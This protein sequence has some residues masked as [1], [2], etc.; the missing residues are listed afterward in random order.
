MSGRIGVAGLGLMGSAIAGHLVAAHP[1]RVV[2][3]N[4]DPARSEPLGRLGTDI[5]A[6]PS[7]LA[8]R[9]SVVHLSLLDTAAVEEVAAAI[10]DVPKDDGLIL[11]HST[12]SAVSTREIAARAAQNGWTWVDAPVSGGSTGARAGQ[13]AVFL[14]GP[15]AQMDRARLACTPF[16]RQASHMGPSGAGQATK[17]ANQ[18]IVG[19]TFVLLAE[20][21]IL[22]ERMGV[23]AAL[24]PKVLA[25]GFADSTLLQTQLPR[26]VSGP[27]DIQ[28]T[29]AVML[30]DLNLVAD[31]A[32]ASRTATPLADA[33]RAIWS[34]HVASGHGDTDWTEIAAR[35]R[36][37]SDTS[38]TTG[39]GAI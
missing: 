19:G 31:L 26:M 20:A 14:G 1:G 15:E 22:A 35:V 8:A 36:A 9:C 34:D 17:A 18:L 7:D 16:A 2:V 4:R 6:S 38:A 3:W 30:K 12:I 33:A 37:A 39:G 24:M 29:A 11:D 32:A 5:A 25:G 27:G 10:L 13:L 23:D 21:A 28:G